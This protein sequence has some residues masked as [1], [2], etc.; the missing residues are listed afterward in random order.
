MYL[1]F[2]VCHCCCNKT[3]FQSDL[4]IYLPIYLYIFSQ[5]FRK[6]ACKGASQH[7][8]NQMSTKSFKRKIQRNRV[9]RYDQSYVSS[10]TS[11]IGFR[12]RRHR[13]LL[14]RHQPHSGRVKTARNWPLE[15]DTMHIYYFCQRNLAIQT[16]YEPVFV[17]IFLLHQQQHM[18]QVSR[19][20]LV[21]VTIDPK[22]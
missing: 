11:Y 1:I 21:E 17:E 10:H 15:T 16:S 3:I 8:T 19:E 7:N 9:A 12:E 22:H 13:Y 4:S 2:C 18:K 20:Q 5:F 6:E 14:S